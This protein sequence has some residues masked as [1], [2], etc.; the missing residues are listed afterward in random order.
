MTKK[1]TAPTQGL[2]FSPH[3]L[4]FIVICL[5]PII[6]ILVKNKVEFKTFFN[7]TRELYVEEAE[8]HINETSTNKRG[9]ISS[10]AYQTGLDRREVSSI[11]KN[12]P[13]K[14]V[15]TEQNRSR[16]GFIL[17]SWHNDPM[18]CD[19]Q[20]Q[21]LP[22]KRSGPG[23]SFETL[24]QRFGKN[25]S[26]G[27]ILNELIEAGCV[28]VTQD[29]VRFI[30]PKYTPSSTSD[31]QKI[32]IASLS[33]NRLGNTLAHN[34]SDSDDLIFQRNLYSVR[35]KKTDVQLFKEEVA[36][37]INEVLSDVITPRF[38]A[39]EEKYQTNIKTKQSLPVG[40]GLFY[41]EQQNIEKLS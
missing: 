9:K 16:E 13:S 41:F 22:L 1:Q 2:S 21:P 3:W 39:I 12:K 17:D 30:T 23:L 20:G 10:I 18:F 29:K 14:E 26:H 4:N 36:E 19:E 40:L 32:S 33:M 8:R 24:V 7:L 31:G 6:R 5:R 28:E 34:L 25:I 27:P 11:I 35:I 37:M 38:D 15:V